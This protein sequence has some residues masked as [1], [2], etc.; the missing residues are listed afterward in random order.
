M[1]CLSRC[2]SAT[3]MKYKWWPQKVTH[4]LLAPAP[5]L[6]GFHH[7]LHTPKEGLNYGQHAHNSDGCVKVTGRL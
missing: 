2:G 7:M 3:H 6:Q 4:H 5:M 1:A